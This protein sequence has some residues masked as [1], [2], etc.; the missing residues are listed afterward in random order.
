MKSVTSV[1]AALLALLAGCSKSKAPSSDALRAG[2]LLVQIALEPDPPRAG[3][4]V[5]HV[6][7]KD[8]QGKPVD[9]VRVGLIYDM[10]AMGAMPEMKGH[11]ESKP[12]GGGKYDVSYR[13]AMLGDWYIK[14]GIEAPGHP[15]AE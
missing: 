15:P 3:D 13:L 12:R 6:T 9:G 1:V 7:V 2:D 4:N 10:P 5:L 14:L 11:G 8:T